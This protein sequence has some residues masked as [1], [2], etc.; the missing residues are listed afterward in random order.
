MGFRGVLVNINMTGLRVCS[1]SIFVHGRNLVPSS[2]LRFS[3]KLLSAG[4]IKTR[5]LFGVTNNLL[6]PGV[7]VEH[8]FNDARQGAAGSVSSFTLQQLPRF[9]LPFPLRSQPNH[10]LPLNIP[11]VLNS[12]RRQFLA[13]SN[14][15]SSTDE[16]D[17]PPKEQRHEK[18]L[19]IPNI[20]TGARIAMTP[21]IA[22]TIIDG[23]YETALW[24]LAI[25]GFSD[26]AD[27]YIARNVPGQSSVI[28]GVIDPVADKILIGVVTVS[29]GC[30]GLIPAWMTVIIIGRE[31]GLIGGSLYVRY[32]SLLAHFERVT[33]KE[34]WDLRHPTV[35]VTPNYLGKINTVIQIFTL[36]CSLSIPAFG[37]DGGDALTALWMVT[38]ATTF[39]S[40]LVYL[41]DMEMSFL[42]PRTD[43]FLHRWPEWVK[44]RV[45]DKQ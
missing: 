29:L 9:L 36:F 2:N 12:E 22:A 13:T 8:H 6:Q 44:R 18:L 43:E 21:F 37:I 15:N 40:G 28:G 16:R 11:P 24:L 35:V 7:P 38:S 17:S 23:S 20:I 4:R 1:S 25:A 32:I 30:A 31:I 34:F 42:K 26:F 5:K 27:G 19:T 3:D 10:E 45:K 39:A 14:S 33:M 41:T